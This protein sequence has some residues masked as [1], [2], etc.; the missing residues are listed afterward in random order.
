M[1]HLS[2]G[3]A[4]KLLIGREIEATKRA[5]VAVHPTQGLDVGAAEN[6]RTA[7]LEARAAHIPVLLI[8]EDLGELISLADRLVVM[9]EGRV[10]G[11]FDSNADLE[12]IGLLM[13]GRAA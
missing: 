12:S 8:S 11:Q 4:Q 5:L 2:G 1:R 9:Y 6:A 7:L 13:G 3:N 10:V